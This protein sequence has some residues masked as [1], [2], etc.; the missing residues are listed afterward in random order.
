MVPSSNEPASEIPA[1]LAASRTLTP[2]NS[3]H[4]VRD[5]RNR[6]LDSFGI[7][8][9]RNPRRF[10]QISDPASTLTPV[11]LPPSR[12]RL[13]TSPET[14][15]SPAT[16]T[17]GIVDVAI[18]N[19]NARRV[20]V[21]R[22]RSGCVLTTSR[23]RSSK[24]CSVHPSP[25]YRSTTRFRPSIYPRRLSSSKKRSVTDARDHFADFKRW[26]NNCDAIHLRRLSQ[27]TP[28][29]GRKH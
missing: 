10:P 22:I 1:L 27:R 18:L 26:V 19:F 5:P 4:T 23:A 20:E 28:H 11:I 9:S 25:E 17:I 21:E 24:C 7:A 3:S 12:A 14:I 29:R 2:P 15:G 8:S 16:A 6:V 13:G